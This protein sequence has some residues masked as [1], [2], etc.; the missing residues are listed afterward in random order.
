M[1][2]KDSPPNQGAYSTCG[3]GKVLSHLHRA[4]ILWLGQ[5]QPGT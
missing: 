3:T 5:G 1:V 2:G 4:A